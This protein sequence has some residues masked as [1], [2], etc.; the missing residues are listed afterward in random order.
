MIENG[1]DSWLSQIN[2][3][4]TGRPLASQQNSNSRNRNAGVQRSIDRL[5]DRIKQAKKDDNAE[6]VKRL[7][8]QL[9][10][11]KERAK[12]GRDNKDRNRKDD[13][14]ADDKPSANE[15]PMDAETLVRQAYLRTLSRQPNEK[16]LSRS[17]SYIDGEKSQIDGL[18]GLMWALI[19]TKEFI[20]NH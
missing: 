8:A 18:R 19:N 4:L 20:V 10:Q 3:Q 16:E 17:I 15:K 1:R 5:E 12:R 6:Q 11:L 2:Q 13:G 14:K 7:T 9:R